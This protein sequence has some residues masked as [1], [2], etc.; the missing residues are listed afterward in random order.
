MIRFCTAIAATFLLAGCYRPPL[1]PPPIVGH[2]Q[3][4]AAIQEFLVASRDLAVALGFSDVTFGETVLAVAPQPAALNFMQP[5]RRRDDASFTLGNRAPRSATDVDAAVAYYI[6]TGAYASMAVCRNYLAGLRERNDYF[7]FLQKE[8]NIAG[9]I[10]TLTLGLAS[11]NP[12]LITAISGVKDAINQGLDVYQEFRYLS[13]EVETIIPVV[14]AAQLALKDYFLKKPTLEAKAV[15]KSVKS[16]QTSGKLTF[17]FDIVTTTTVTAKGIT[18][19]VRTFAG[20]VYAVNK[21]D[22]ACTRSGVKSI[23]NKSL[24]QAAPKF[25]VEN[26]ILVAVAADKAAAK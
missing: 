6:E 15:S 1:S 10:A 25:N 22:Y 14:E 17:D 12:T 24:I 9:G 4:N 2:Y 20:A 13:V 18:P 7:E 23:I 11:A 16:T 3:T 26:G 5:Q 8:F 19:A 21:I